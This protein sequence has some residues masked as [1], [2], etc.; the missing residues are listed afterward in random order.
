MTRAV[1]A[2]HG[3]AGAITRAAMSAEKEQHYRQQLHAIVSAGQADPGH[4]GQCAGRGDEGSAT[5][6]RVSVV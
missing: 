3:G 1:I 2:I 6:G 4:W 5:A